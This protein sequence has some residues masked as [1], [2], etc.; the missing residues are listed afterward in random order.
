M[1]K[2]KVETHWGLTNGSIIDTTHN[3][4]IQTCFREKDLG[5]ITLVTVSFP[6][7]GPIGQDIEYDLGFNKDGKLEL[8][9]A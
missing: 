3:D 1:T 2:I 5:R 8:V 4:D 6:E 9:K 7:A